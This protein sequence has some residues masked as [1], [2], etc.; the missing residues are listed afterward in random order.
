MHDV[1]EATRVAEQKSD[2]LTESGVSKMSKKEKLSLIQRLEAEMKEAAKS[3]QFE[4]AAELR[5]ALL[6]LRAELD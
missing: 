4:R 2:Y 5:D 1:I 3:L 6:E